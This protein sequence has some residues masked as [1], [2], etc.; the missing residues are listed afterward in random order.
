MS[1]AAKSPKPGTRVWNSV[2][3]FALS[4]SLGASV[5]PSIKWG[6]ETRSGFPG[7]GSW[8]FLP[9]NQQDACDKQPGPQSPSDSRVA[10]Q[11]ASCPLRPQ[12]VPRVTDVWGSWAPDGDGSLPALMSGL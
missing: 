4:C 3:R 6:Q 2:A 7:A 9:H 11:I 1:A 8:T 12:L 5:L 10:A